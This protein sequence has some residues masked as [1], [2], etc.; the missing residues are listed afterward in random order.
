VQTAV[1]R[2][3]VHKLSI[4]QCRL[5]YTVIHYTSCL[6]SSADRCMQTYYTHKLSTFQCRLLYTDILHTQAVY[7]PVQTAVYRH[8]VHKL[9]TFQHRPL[10]TD[11][12][13]QYTSCRLLCTDTLRTQAVLQRSACSST[14][15]FF[16]FIYSLFSLLKL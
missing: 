13:V 15:L 4:F 12:Q 10:Y 14:L 5:L 11:I 1:Y 8:T 9:S 3:T 7:L 16:L 6:P 2:H